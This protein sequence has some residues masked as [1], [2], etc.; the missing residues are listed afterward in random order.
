LFGHEHAN[1][2][3]ATTA[4]INARAGSPPKPANALRGVFH[5]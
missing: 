2:S 1:S 3:I 4:S 5:P